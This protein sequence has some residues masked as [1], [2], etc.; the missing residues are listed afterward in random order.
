MFGLMYSN[1]YQLDQVF[2]SETRTDMALGM[3]AT[4]PTSC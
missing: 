3:G 2:F 4:M 1:T